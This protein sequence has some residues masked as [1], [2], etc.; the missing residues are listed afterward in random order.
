LILKV[1]TGMIPESQ[2]VHQFSIKIFSKKCYLTW[3]AFKCEKLPKS[4]KGSF[5]S[6]KMR[7]LNRPRRVDIESPHWHDTWESDGTSIFNKN[8]LQKMLFNLRRFQVW[9]ITKIKK[10]S[11]SI[12]IV[13]P[14]NWPL[15][16]DIESTN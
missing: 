14:L 4:I 3:G 11:F 2:M 9:K 13:T 6:G 15:R 10:D 1:H 8:L 5:Y 16:V 7:P 12:R